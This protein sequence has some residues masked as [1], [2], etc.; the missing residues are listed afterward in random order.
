MQAASTG[1]NEQGHDD[2][3]EG[4]NEVSS[5]T[6]L[7]QRILISDGVPEENDI[8][9]SEFEA[10]VQQPTSG[11]EANSPKPTNKLTWYRVLSE[12]KKYKYSEF[13][14]ESPE[15]KALLRIVLAH[16][17]QLHF[18]SDDVNES[19]T[20]PSPFEE[21]IHNWDKLEAISNGDSTEYNQLRKSVETFGPRTDDQVNYL[22]SAMVRLAQHG[23]LDEA[24]QQLREMLMRIRSTPELKFFF[25]AIN[26][27]EKRRSVQFDYLW[28]IFPPGEIVYSSVFMREPQLFIVKQGYES[29]Q[30]SESGR[31]KKRVWKLICWSY[32]WNGKTFN[33][34][35]VKFIF[36]EFQG[37]RGI[38]T[39]DAY[40]LKF[41][42]DTP[43]CSTEQLREQLHRRGERFR[44]LCIRRKGKQMFQYEGDAITRGAGFQ[45]L[46][47]R[48]SKSL[49]IS[50]EKR[51]KKKL[52]ITFG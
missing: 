27:Q 50:R 19:M 9:T 40:P 12:Q 16:Y 41:R 29:H 8:S 45:K 26:G 17:P 32:D 7:R 21:L 6:R 3:I 25:S 5:M 39:L 37:S 28:T 14:I 52:I 42:S 1:E 49:K 51:K 36:E 31:E 43:T 48:V 24:R 34:V 47:N 20:F 22:A 23:S 11:K 38:E 44:E 46:G 30:S 13:S 33:R 18:P 4:G 15:L 10:L 2:R 35:P